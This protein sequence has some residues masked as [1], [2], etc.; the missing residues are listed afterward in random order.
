MHHNP[1]LVPLA[2][3]L[4]LRAVLCQKVLPVVL[5]RDEKFI[6]DGVPGLEDLV[7]QTQAC[8]DQDRDGERHGGGGGV[9][10]GGGGGVC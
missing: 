1:L 4:P 9:G 8:Q 3:G 6:A 5:T 10:G 7:D 2:V